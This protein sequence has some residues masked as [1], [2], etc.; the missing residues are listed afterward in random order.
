M[1]HLELFKKFDTVGK[2]FSLTPQRLWRF[3]NVLVWWQVNG[4]RAVYLPPHQHVC[5]APQALRSQRKE[6]PNS[7]ELFEKFEMTHSTVGRPDV[8]IYIIYK[9]SSHDIYSPHQ[10]EWTFRLVFAQHCGFTIQRHLSV[11]RLYLTEF[12]P[13][14]FAGIVKAAASTGIRF[15]TLADVEMTRENQRKLYEL[16][17]T[18][19]EICSDCPC[20][21]GKA[22]GSIW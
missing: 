7:I 15:F 12:N 1:S 10:R 19:L 14:P 18:L 21:T 11:P 16:Q 4:P 6:F 22:K 2:L 9:E 17:E 5:E 8:N 13:V 20:K 3:A